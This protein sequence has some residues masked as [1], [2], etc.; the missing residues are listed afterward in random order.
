MIRALFIGIAHR[1]LCAYDHYSALTRK[2]AWRKHRFP[3]FRKR[4]SCAY[5]KQSHEH[6]PCHSIIRRE[7]TVEQRNTKGT[8][9][10]SH[11]TPL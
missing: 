10:S 2:Y 11:W 5:D 6:G 4:R 1:R 7:G 3:R 9:L 8:M